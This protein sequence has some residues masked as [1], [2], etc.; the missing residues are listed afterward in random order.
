MNICFIALGHIG[1][2]LAANLVKADYTVTVYRERWISGETAEFVSC[3]RPDYK[4]WI[5]GPCPKSLANARCAVTERSA[6]AAR[7]SRDDTWLRRNAFAGAALRA[8][9]FDSK[10]C[11]LLAKS[12]D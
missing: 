12:E 11:R 7:S 2:G 10:S 8:D 4:F 6:D 1:S 9:L 3:S 5:V